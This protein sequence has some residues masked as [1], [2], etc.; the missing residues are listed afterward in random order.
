MGGV[1]LHTMCA[2]GSRTA[3]P[4][5][6]SSR[7]WLTTSSIHA[8]PRFS[9][10]ASTQHAHFSPSPNPRSLSPPTRHATM[11]LMLITG[12]QKSMSILST[13][14]GSRYV[15]NNGSRRLCLRTGTHG[16]ELLPCMYEEPQGKDVR[17]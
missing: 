17:E 11:P 4:L 9:A 1:W 2:T 13:A 6:A 14:L 5:G 3:S 16:R 12:S 7:D 10:P 15:H 8:P